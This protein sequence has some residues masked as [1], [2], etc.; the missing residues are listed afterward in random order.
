MVV[1]RNI[2]VSA[3]VFFLATLF[4]FSG[5]L[6]RSH[7]SFPFVSMGN[8]S[9]G[10]R[11]PIIVRNELEKHFQIFE[12]TPL[13]FV[14]EGEVKEVSPEEIGLHLN[15][16]STLASVPLA[17]PQHSWKFF[18]KI[19]KPHRITPVFSFDRYQ[20]IRALQEKFSTVV[21]K[22]EA[23]FSWD[24]KQK[25]IIV[26]QEQ[27]GYVFQEEELFLALEDR[28]KHFSSDPIIL[29]ARIENPEIHAT[30]L[31]PF[32]GQAIGLLPKTITITTPDGIIG[33]WKISFPQHIHLLSWKYRGDTNSPLPYEPFF[34][35][36]AVNQFL[37]DAEI[38]QNIERGTGKMH[39]STDEEKK[40]AFEGNSIPGR[41]IDR[42]KFITLLNEFSPSFVLP[43]L[44]I[45]AEVEISGELQ[46]LGIRE[47][48]GRGYTTFYGSPKNRIHNINVGVKTYDGLLVPPGG[49][50]S[51]NENLGEVEASTGYKPELVI[52]PEGTIPEFGGGLCQVSTTM[53]RA[54]LYT[55]L[56]IVDRSPHSYAVTYYSQIGGHGIDATIYPGSKDLKILNDTPG[57]ILIHAYA[58]QV[59]AAFEFFGTKDGREVTME[60]P[61]ITNKIGPPP[62]Q[63]IFT[64][65]IP[66]G[67]KTLKEK[68]HGGFSATWYRYVKKGGETIKETIFS[69]Y[70]AMPAK[71]IIG[72]EGPSQVD[73]VIEAAKQFE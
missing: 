15:L 55:G 48:I 39:I 18:W 4:L 69:R 8:I 27:A 24:P 13:L 28:T 21:L 62:D 29:H 14:F 32:K 31:E 7:V 23:S 3:F 66:A 38:T 40:I 72:G 12:Q 63:I 9:L 54:A 47:L 19:V 30:D 1:F 56:P 34:N 44:E 22:K 60:G 52:K 6:S 64:T 20:V 65:D 42:E 61:Y 45:P 73:P 50:F 2:I 25:E 26:T 58:D 5:M 70:R 59:S 35:E 16:D 43:I 53:Y 17:L 51:F 67:K 36:N 10:L 37:H 68:P 71:Y 49:T 11:T 57:Y 33:E 46:T 41:E